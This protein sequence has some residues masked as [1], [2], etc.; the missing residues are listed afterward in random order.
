M[1]FQVS[2]AHLN[3][4]LLISQS[5]ISLRAYICQLIDLRLLHL[6]AAH[7]G[8]G[9]MQVSNQTRPPHRLWWLIF[10]EAWKMILSYDHKESW[11]VRGMIKYEAVSLFLQLS[12]E[13]TIKSTKKQQLL[14]PPLE[15]SPYYLASSILCVLFL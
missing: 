4:A 8:D 9:S 12:M 2:T 1:V 3:S 11:I 7:S 15:K 13:H 6:A 5:T 14:H 10:P